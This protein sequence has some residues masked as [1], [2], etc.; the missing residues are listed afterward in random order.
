MGI[1]WVIDRQ[2]LREQCAG[3]GVLAVLYT[4]AEECVQVVNLGYGRQRRHTRISEDYNG[5][6]QVRAT[7]TRTVP[8]QPLARRTV[9]TQAPGTQLL[10]L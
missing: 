3:V 2:F 7:R 5:T 1:R 10:P 4:T 9:A 6:R 8:W